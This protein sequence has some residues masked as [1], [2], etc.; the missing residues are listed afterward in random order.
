MSFCSTGRR[1]IAWSIRRQRPTQLP[2]P[3][4]P[5]M[6][7]NWIPPLRSFPCL[8]APATVSEVSALNM[9][10]SCW[11]KVWMI[12]CRFAAWACGRRRRYSP[13]LSSGSAGGPCRP[14]IC[15]LRNP[16][17]KPTI[18]SC[19]RKSARRTTHR[20]ACASMRSCVYA[21]NTLKRR[22]K[23]FFT[24]CMKRRKSAMLQSCAF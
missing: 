8:F 13:Q 12:F 23:P 19:Q 4:R 15:Q 21:M 24:V 1:S 22:A 17:R 6:M 2:W 10:P 14:W 7:Q 16:V 5:W 20:R 9:P 3:P 18:P 11:E